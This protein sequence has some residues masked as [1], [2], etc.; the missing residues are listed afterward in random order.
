MVFRKLAS[1]V[2]CCGHQ[3]KGLSLGKLHGTLALAHQCTQAR[4]QSLCPEGRRGPI[5]S[6]IRIPL[7]EY[8]QA[9]FCVVFAEVT[10]H[11]SW[12]SRLRRH[13]Q[14][15]AVPLESEGAHTGLTMGGVS[16]AALAPSASQLHFSVW[17]DWKSWNPLLMWVS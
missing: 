5:N 1:T 11:L 12:D 8:Q 16:L 15:P 2:S 4:I 3:T 7:H 13:C 6:Q 17:L 9:A 14:R 10:V